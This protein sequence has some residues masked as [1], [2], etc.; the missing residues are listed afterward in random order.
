MRTLSLN[1]KGLKVDFLRFNLPF[2]NL[3][4]SHAIANY[5]RDN[6]HC[7]SKSTSLILVMVL[8]R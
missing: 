6:F 1:S 5:L 4:Q 2:T 8:G 7:K 3:Y